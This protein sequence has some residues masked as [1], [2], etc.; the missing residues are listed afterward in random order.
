MMT[1]RQANI[2]GVAAILVMLALLLL[3]AFQ[4]VPAS[5]ELP[6]FMLAALLFAGRLVL[7]VAL[8][9]R[10]RAERETHDPPAG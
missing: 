1:D 8:A 4:M 7:R 10:K 3:V 2:L 9:R 6:L 5:W